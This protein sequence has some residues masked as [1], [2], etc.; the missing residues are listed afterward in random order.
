MASLPVSHDPTAPEPTLSRTIKDSDDKK[1]SRVPNRIKSALFLD[2]DNIYGGLHA[3]DSE[4]ATDMANEPWLWLEKVLAQAGSDGRRDVL[5]KRAYLNPAGRVVNRDGTRQY[6][7]SIRPQLTRAGFE[8][9]DCPSLTSTGKNAADIRIVMDVLEYLSRSCRYEEFVIASSDADFTP[10]LH[11]LRSDDRRAIVIASGQTSTAYRQVADS[12]LDIGELL[13]S[14]QLKEDPKEGTEHTSA[15]RTSDSARS[16]APSEQKPKAIE[17]AVSYMEANDEPV[18]LATF[19]QRLRSSLNPSE[20]LEDWFGH[21]TFGRFLQSIRSS[22]VV[23]GHHVWDTARHGMPTDQ[24]DMLPDS[25]RRICNETELPRLN[26][27]R[28]NA[29]F[30]VMARY[31]H[32]HDFNLTH[33]TAWCRDEL[34]EQG[35]GIGRAQIGHVVRSALYGGQPLNSV[36]APTEEQIRSA[37]LSSAVA[38]A[39][40]VHLNLTEAEEVELSAWLG[41][42]RPSGS[43]VN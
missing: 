33:C 38:R 8:I 43:T 42:A 35:V 34:R 23:E 21:Q 9:I 1:V 4:Q 36:P 28:W 14:D 24:S 15:T 19:A 6:F 30:E 10:L 27:S 12:V 7:S 26:T 32:E 18:L 25:I 41:G 37:V 40:A 3:L 31:A 16:E 5:V 39:H 2:F 20:D 17:A 13:E 29:L 22:Y 11:H